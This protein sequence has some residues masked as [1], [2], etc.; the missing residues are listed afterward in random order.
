METQKQFKKELI[1]WKEYK[2]NIRYQVQR[3][4][5]NKTKRKPIVIPVIID[6]SKDT[7]CEII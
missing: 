3:Y 1:D 7:I 2:D 5:S 6:V 4:L